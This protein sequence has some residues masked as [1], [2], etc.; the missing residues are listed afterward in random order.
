MKTDDWLHIADSV[1]DDEPDS[2][3]AK[4]K[5]DPSEQLSNRILV[6]R[7][8]ALPGVQSTAVVN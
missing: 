2:A 7:V 1:C 5:D 8:K 4:Y 6:N 3:A